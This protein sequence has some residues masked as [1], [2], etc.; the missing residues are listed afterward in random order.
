MNL[1][2]DVVGLASE[3]YLLHT[4]NVASVLPWQGLKVKPHPPVKPK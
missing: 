3:G 4:R 2:S 1:S